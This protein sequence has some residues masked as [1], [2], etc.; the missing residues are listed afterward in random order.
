METLKSKHCKQEGVLLRAEISVPPRI[1]VTT[2]RPNIDVVCNP[3]LGAAVHL[4]FT[5]PS[6]FPARRPAVLYVY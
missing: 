6:L 2:I 4:E 3:L 5:V 1:C